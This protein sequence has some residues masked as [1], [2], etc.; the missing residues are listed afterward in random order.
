MSWH[1]AQRVLTLDLPASEKW[2]LYVL[3]L[4]HGEHGCYPSEATLIADTGHSESTLRR[5]LRKLEKR[6]R[7]TVTHDRGRSNRYRL[8]LGQPDRDQTPVNLTGVHP[9]QSDRTPR[10]KDAQ[11]PV[12]LTGNRDKQVKR[13]GTVKMTARE[14][15]EYAPKRATRQTTSHDPFGS[16][17]SLAQIVAD[18]ARP[19]VG[20]LSY[21]EA[22]ERMKLEPIP[23]VKPP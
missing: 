2:T 10:S 23:G 1:L 11:T 3:A 22:M 4:R 16:G 6:G 15:P 8:N 7:I 17:R 21:A 18:R 19:K 5:A 14:K 13:D 20:S 9:G 12:K